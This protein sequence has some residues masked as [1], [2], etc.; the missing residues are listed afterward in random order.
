VTFDRPYSWG[1]GAA[2]FIESQLPMLTLAERLRLPV[3]YAT[4]VDLQRDPAAF[5]QARLVVSTGH[6]EYYSPGMRQTLTDARDHGVNLAFFGANDVYRKIRFADTALGPD[7]AVINYKDDT[8]PIG[9][10]SLVTTQWREPPS[11][12]PESSLTGDDYRCATKVLGPIVVADASNWLFARTG[13]SNGTQL[14]SVAGQEFDGVTPTRPTPRPMT[15]LF[16][17][18]ETCYGRAQTQDSTYYTAPSGAGVLDVG[19]FYWDCAI[20]NSCPVRIDAN[21]TAMITQI[22]T[23]FLVAAAAGPLGRT[24]KAVDNVRTFYPV[25]RP[26]P[27]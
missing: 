22:T 11:S 19:A 4:D 7:R 10:P 13:V 23:T 18:P 21:T 6:D 15:I 24:H 17:S 1:L 5:R 26:A 9:V 27:R 14:A 12:D 20:G 8:D 25:V 2:E 16:H 3:G